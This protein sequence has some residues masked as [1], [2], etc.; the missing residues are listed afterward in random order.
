[1][2]APAAIRG[3]GQSRLH[4]DLLRRE[5]PVPARA[6]REERGCSSGGRLTFEERISSVW[7]G[8]LAAGAAECPVCRGRMEL[9]GPVG[10]CGSCG[11][12]LS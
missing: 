2:S 7:E 12:K 1:M 6:R 10:R 9:A 8:L 11:S 4:E 3:A 5:R